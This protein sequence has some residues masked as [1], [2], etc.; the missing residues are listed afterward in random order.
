VFKPQGSSRIR[1]PEI[2]VIVLTES[3]NDSYIIDAI[4]AGAG[5][6]IFS[7][8]YDTGRVTAEHTQG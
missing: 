4:H 5:G 3:V 2:A 8:G 7:K 1:F 6:Y